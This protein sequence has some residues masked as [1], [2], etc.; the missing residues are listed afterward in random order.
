MTQI[1]TANAISVA[2]SLR[3]TAII[4]IIITIIIINEFNSFSAESSKL[5]KPVGMNNPVLVTSNGTVRW[6][7][8]LI[9]HSS[10]KLNVKYFPFDEQY[11]R[12]SFASWTYSGIQLKIEPEVTN[13]LQNYTG[14]NLILFQEYLI[15]DD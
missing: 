13:I 2:A 9:L 7:T 15:C 11:C 6:L 12:L 3:S 1:S 8:P 14:D 10:C 4:I 5:G